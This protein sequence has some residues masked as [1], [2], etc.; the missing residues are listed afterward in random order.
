MEF[1]LFFFCRD[2]HFE[3]F[4]DLSAFRSKIKFV[5]FNFGPEKAY[6]E[7]SCDV[8]F[9]FFWSTCHLTKKVTDA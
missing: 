5:T 8:S 2:I 7:Y 4:E 1:N 6:I 9:F 3:M